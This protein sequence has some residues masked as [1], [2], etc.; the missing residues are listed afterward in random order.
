MN[1]EYVWRR[2]PSQFHFIKYAVSLPIIKYK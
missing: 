1:M 2:I